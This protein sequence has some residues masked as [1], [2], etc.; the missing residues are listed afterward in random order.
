M[1]K[2]FFKKYIQHRKL[3]QQIIELEIPYG[4]D[5]TFDDMV[6][7]V[8]LLNSIT[9]CTT[10]KIICITFTQNGT[11]RQILIDTKDKVAMSLK[12]N[13]CQAGT[14][15]MYVSQSRSSE[16]SFYG[17]NCL[18]MAESNIVQNSPP[19]LNQTSQAYI[20]MQCLKILNYKMSR[21]N[22]FWTSLSTMP[23]IFK[24]QGCIYEFCKELTPNGQ[25]H[26]DMH[27]VLH[28]F[29]PVKETDPFKHDFAV[30]KVSITIN[31]A[32]AAKH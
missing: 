21:T 23:Y 31:C 25:L 22:L 8:D 18:T 2:M 13:P 19:I 10:P 15:K 6:N 11:N 14:Y 9:I 29:R 3:F 28:A 17:Q 5:M 20:W 26:D 32:W 30:E 1:T 4:T 16:L 27:F 24:P 12:V 7:D